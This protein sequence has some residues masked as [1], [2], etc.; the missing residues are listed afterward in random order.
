V[1]LDR[2]PQL[3]P[4]R[5]TEVR[6]IEPVW[7]TGEQDGLESQRCGAL[8]LAHAVVDVPEGQRRHRNQPPWIDR[9]PLE[10]P[11]VV[12][13]NAFVHEVTVFE[14]QET[15]PAEAADVGV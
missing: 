3:V 7:F 14:A 4:V 5:V 15:L 12:R 10:L 8:D 13:T 2:C 11:V 9:S 6:E 1:C